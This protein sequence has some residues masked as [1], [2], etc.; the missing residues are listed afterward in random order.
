MVCIYFVPALTGF[1]SL[2]IGINM[3]RAIWESLE[4][5][6]AHIE[7]CLEGVL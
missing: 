5:T 1:R 2:L 7:N 4:A 6:N 3:G